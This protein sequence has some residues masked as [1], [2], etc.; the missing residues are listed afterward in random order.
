MVVVSGTVKEYVLIQVLPLSFLFGLGFYFLTTENIETT[1]IVVILFNLIGIVVFSLRIYLKKL[2][3]LK[4]QNG[5]INIGNEE[6]SSKS[7]LTLTPY[8]YSGQRSL[9]SLGTL[10]IWIKKDDANETLETLYV[11]LKPTTIFNKK[12]K[13]LTNLFA[14]FP[15]LESKLKTKIDVNTSYT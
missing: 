12:S 7:I 13:T 3:T 14:E 5:I 8:V 11:L 9:V 10:Q 2:K 6:V 1:F 15:E 4:I